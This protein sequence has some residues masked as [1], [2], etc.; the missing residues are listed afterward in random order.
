MTEKIRESQ[1]YEPVRQFWSAA[2]YLVR[3]EVSSCDVLACLGDEMIA[4][5]LKASLGLEVVLQAVERQKACNQAW[6]AVPKPSSKVLRSKRWHQILH[7]LKRLELG[8][9]LIDLEQ[10]PACIE[11]VMIGLPFDR[12]ASQARAKAARKKMREEF[13]RRHGDQNTGGINR[14]RLMTAY[15]EQALLVAALLSRTGIASAAQLR[16]MGSN[17]QTYAILRKNYYGWFEKCGRGQYTLTEAGQTALQ[18]H[19]GLAS[20]LES[21]LPL[22]TA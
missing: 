20:Q 19:H 7:L 13:D 12:S 8:L 17:S 2:G 16:Q 11:V 14:T 6:V 4:I 1:L 10:Q 21:E 9:M 18:N 3:G 5:E 22:T 15:R